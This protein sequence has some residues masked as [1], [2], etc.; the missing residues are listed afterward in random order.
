MSV[1]FSVWATIKKN[2]IEAKLLPLGLIVTAGT[3]GCL[4]LIGSGLGLQ[5]LYPLPIAPYSQYT[6]RPPPPSSIMWGQSFIAVHHLRNDEFY[7][8]LNPKNVHVKGKG[9]YY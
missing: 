5:N 8:V 6:P 3:D 2:F 1:G 7:D 9:K 4:R